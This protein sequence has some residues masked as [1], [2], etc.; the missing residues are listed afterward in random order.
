MLLAGIVIVPSIITQLSKNHYV[1]A[2]AL[3][4]KSTFSVT[5][6]PSH[7]S[8]SFVIGVSGVETI[9]GG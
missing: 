2:F 3:F 5:H 7:S 1:S 8:V 9:T 6:H 4:V